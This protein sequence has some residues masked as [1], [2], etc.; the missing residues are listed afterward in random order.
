MTQRIGILGGTFDPVHCGHLAL[1]RSARGQYRLDR[2]L[3][4]PAFMPPHKI[5][6]CEI[7]APAHRYRMVE[8]AIGGEPDFEVC[9]VEF[10]REGPSY[11]VETLELLKRR[12]PGSEWFLI[13]GEDN[14]RNM[15]RW[16]DPDRIRAAATVLAAKRPGAETQ[17]FRHARGDLRSPSSQAGAA[18]GGTADEGPG[19]QWIRMEA[20][21]VSASKIRETLRGGGSPGPH[22]L[23][24]AVEDYIRR[25]KLYRA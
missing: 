20:C 10:T 19:V 14:L 18:A 8:L 22:E 3:F 5:G 6:I 25:Q 7:T 1:A 17:W 4:V 12:F 9:D 21:P 11:T 23:P 16:K 2:L 24:T 15:D 13:L